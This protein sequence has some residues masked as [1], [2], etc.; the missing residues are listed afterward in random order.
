MEL[1]L[2][3]AFMISAV[4]HAGIAAPFY[5]QNLLKTDFEKKSAVIVDYLILKE[6]SNIVPGN[7][8]DKESIT[9]AQ[10]PKVE[11]RSAPN[12]NRV[13]VKH[14]K[15]DYRKRLE[16]ARVKEKKST[17][18]EKKEAKLK[19]S[20]DYINYYGLLKDRIKARLQ[21]NYKFYKGEGDV[22]L[23]FVLN[24]KGIL[25]S[26]NIDRSRSS[27]DEVLL[28]ITRASLVAVAPFPALPKS[29]S[30][31]ETSFSITISFKK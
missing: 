18:A 20:K 24:E 4:I 27:K 17:G 11:A 8:S 29:I 31:P 2:K 3:S 23:S 19:S 30:A 1:G 21:G 28:Q 16:A 26:Y 9:V 13:N 7:V 22:Y 15:L 12:D 6:M 5:S 25:L 10:A 14:S